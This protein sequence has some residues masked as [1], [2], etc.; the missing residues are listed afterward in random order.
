M[1]TRFDVERALENSGLPQTARDIGFALCRRMTAG[2]TEIP[3]G[4]SPS[5]TTLARVI[6]VH[7]RTVMRHLRVLERAGWI[8]RNRPAP[9]DA[10]TRHITTSYTVTIPAAPAALDAAADL[11]EAA[12]VVD[13]L[14]KRTGVIVPAEWAAKIRAEI[15]AKPG[16]R[17]PGAFIRKVIRTEENPKRWLPTPELPP[18]RELR[19]QLREEN[20]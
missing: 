2:G 7:R 18:W 15:L 19:E 17:N 6:G 5:L 13:E 3:A 14:E 20:Q 9:H 4:F 16:I 8:I 11:Q 10:R 12:I 1:P